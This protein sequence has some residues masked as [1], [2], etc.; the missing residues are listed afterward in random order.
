MTT[1]LNI[2]DLVIPK[3]ELLLEK[4]VTVEKL[5]KLE[6]Y[7]KPVDDKVSSLQVKMDGFES[8]K[9][10]AAHKVLELDKGMNLA[11]TER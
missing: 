3:L 7:V 6:E 11:N 8:F 1:A 2:A 4:L 5:E 9:R 10:E